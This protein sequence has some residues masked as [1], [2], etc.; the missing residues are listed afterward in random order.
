MK[1]KLIPC[2]VQYLLVIVNLNPLILQLMQIKLVS[3]FRRLFFVKKWANPGLFYVY[4]HYFQI[5]I[6]MTP[7]FPVKEFSNIRFLGHHVIG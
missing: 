3:S 4:F 6:Q 7:L 5:T 2:T 1:P